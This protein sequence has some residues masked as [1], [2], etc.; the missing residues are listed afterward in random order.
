MRH[1]ASRNGS[2]GARGVRATER[3]IREYTAALSSEDET[4]A[5]YAREYLA[6][7]GW[8]A[9]TREDPGAVRLIAGPKPK[10]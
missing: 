9:P 10:P 1:G 5:Q 2:I 8:Q 4:E 7:I 6:S 3:R